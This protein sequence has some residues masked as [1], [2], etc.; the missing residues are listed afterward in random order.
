MLKR[1]S[2]FVL[3]ILPWALAGLIGL[4]LVAGHMA[5]PSRADAKAMSFA[6]VLPPSTNGQSR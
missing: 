1:L 4:F 5:P 3:E 6:Q 2:I